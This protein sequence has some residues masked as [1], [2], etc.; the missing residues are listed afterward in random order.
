LLACLAVRSSLL[1]SLYRDSM[2]VK[3]EVTM[4]L[5]EEKTFSYRKEKGA[6]L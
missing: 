5:Q 2:G 3:Y 6:A 4:L 1:L